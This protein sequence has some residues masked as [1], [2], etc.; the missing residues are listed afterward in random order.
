MTFPQALEDWKKYWEEKCPHI[1]DDDDEMAA[2]N[3]YFK[4]LDGFS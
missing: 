2:F 1:E 4:D 3:E